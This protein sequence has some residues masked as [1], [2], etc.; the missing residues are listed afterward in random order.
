MLKHAEWRGCF[1][2]IIMIVVDQP[3][4]GSCNSSH[5][6]EDPERSKMQQPFVFQT[7]VVVAEVGIRV[8]LVV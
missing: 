3:G 7:F 2:S 8:L 1:C 4:G 5:D 6:D